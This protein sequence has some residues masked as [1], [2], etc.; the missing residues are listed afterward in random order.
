MDVVCCVVCA[1]VRVRAAVR[2]TAASLGVGGH[3]PEIFF[4]QLTVIQICSHLRVHFKYNRS[5]SIYI[6][7]F[8]FMVNKFQIFILLI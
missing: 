7:K 3:A 4:R 1:S 5:L 8:H 2:K 6:H